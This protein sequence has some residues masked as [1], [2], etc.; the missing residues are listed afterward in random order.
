MAGNLSDY[1]EKKL[2]DHL[3][4]TTSYTMPSAV[5]LAL[6]TAAPTDS[7]GGTE[8]TGGSYVRKVVTFNGVTS[9]S[10]STTNNTT[11][12]FTGMPAC[13]VVA[14]AVLDAL[15]SGNILVYGTLST[16]KTLDSGDILRVASGDLSITIA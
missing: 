10:G 3:L 5:Y 14:V 13:T 9:G 15:T 2:L 6:Y 12:D 11:L 8:V 7:S 1:A 4:G 16:N